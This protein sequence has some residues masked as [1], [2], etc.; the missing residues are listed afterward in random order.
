MYIVNENA[1]V[2]EKNPETWTSKLD[3][4]LPKVTELVRGKVGSSGELQVHFSPQLFSQSLTDLL[5][6]F[7]PQ[8]FARKQGN[9][10]HP[11]PP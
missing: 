10:H 3:N 4:D 5:N 2:D 7:S 6:S 1:F 11:L 8:N 9:K